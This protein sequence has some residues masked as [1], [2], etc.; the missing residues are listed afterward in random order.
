M[1]LRELR[2]YVWADTEAQQDEVL[3]K[4]KERIG[5]ADPLLVPPRRGRVRL[6]TLHG[7]KG[8]TARYVFIP[9][10][11]EQL[12]PGGFRRNYPGLIEEAARLLYVGMTRARIG[13]ILSRAAWRSHQGRW[14]RMTPSRF[15]ASTG[16]AFANHKGGFGQ[17][18]LSALLEDARNL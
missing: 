3:R 1:T 18:V 14:T 9:G 10:L 2:D 8:L 6:M 13:L 11:E 4:A 12:F 16:G 7:S 15:A 5:E 17:D